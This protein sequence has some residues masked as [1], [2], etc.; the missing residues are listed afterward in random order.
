MADTKKNNDVV[1]ITREEAESLNEL[2]ECNLLQ[3]VRDDREIDSLQWLLNILNIWK[4][5][6]ALLSPQEESG[7]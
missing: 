4:K 6:D 1:T 5:C 3:V 2:L 7:A